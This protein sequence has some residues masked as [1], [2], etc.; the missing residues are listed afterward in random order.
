MVN[1]DKTLHLLLHRPIRHPYVE[2]LIVRLRRL[3]STIWACVVHDPYSLVHPLSCFTYLPISF[4]IN[5][6]MFLDLALLCSLMRS[7][8]KHEVSF[9]L[10]LA[11]LPRDSMTATSRIHRCLV[12]DDVPSL[13]PS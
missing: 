4:R 1:R 7:T 10:T 13:P 12:C 6:S 3:A 2:V 11:R 8:C 5:A 9:G